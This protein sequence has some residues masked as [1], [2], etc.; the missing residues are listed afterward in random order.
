ML[1]LLSVPDAGIQIF[2]NKKA[3]EWGKKIWKGEPRKK[4]FYS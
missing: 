3:F 1:S 4:R 2:L